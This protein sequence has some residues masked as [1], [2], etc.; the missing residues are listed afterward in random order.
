MASYF[1]HY[2]SPDEAAIKLGISEKHLIEL[3]LCYDH[4]PERIPIY[5]RIPKSCLVR[6]VLDPELEHNGHTGPTKGDQAL[7]PG[8]Y[9]E[10]HPDDGHALA[11]RPNETHLV[12][13]LRSP[14]YSIGDIPARSL[15]ILWKGDAIPLKYSECLIGE[16]HLRKEIDGAPKLTRQINAILKAALLLGFNPMAVPDSGKRRVFE[17]CARA[18][19]TLFNAGSWENAFKRAWQVRA[20]IVVRL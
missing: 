17:E 16:S 14:A 20:S 19:K 8:Q 15:I 7:S 12:Q 5:C 11:A 4:V 18:N 1:Q 3:V 13:R 6:W 9:F 2:Y 10:I